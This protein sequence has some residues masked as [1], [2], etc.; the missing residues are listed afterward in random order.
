MP[1]KDFD[2]C[3]PIAKVSNPVATFCNG[4][5]VIRSGQVD[6]VNWIGRTVRQIQEEAELHKVLARS[7]TES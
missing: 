3:L 2:R 7:L 6:Y 4:C 5:E 1:V